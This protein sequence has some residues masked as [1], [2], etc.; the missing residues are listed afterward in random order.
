MERKKIILARTKEYQGAK[1]Q[2]RKD[3]IFISR[4]NKSRLRSPDDDV[5]PPSPLRYPPIFLVGSS[6]SSSLNWMFRSSSLFLCKPLCRRPPHTYSRMN[7]CREFFPEYGVLPVANI[8]ARIGMCC[9]ETCSIASEDRSVIGSIP[10]G[11]K[12][13]CKLVQAHYPQQAATAVMGGNVRDTVSN[14]P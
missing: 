3:A 2:K 14:L 10:C 12:W 1:T 8:H 6:A 9:H 4:K 5:N 7:V 11:H 13:L